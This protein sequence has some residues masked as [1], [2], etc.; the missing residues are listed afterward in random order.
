MKSSQYVSRQGKH[1]IDWQPRGNEMC[2]FVLYFLSS[3]VLTASVLARVDGGEDNDIAT[4]GVLKLSTTCKG[5]NVAHARFGNCGYG[6]F[7]GYSFGSGKTPG[8]S[9]VPLKQDLRTG[10]VDGKGLSYSIKVDY[11]GFP[12]MEL[13]YDRR[14]RLWRIVLVATGNDGQM[15]KMVRKVKNDLV[16][17]YGFRKQDWVGV[18]RGDVQGVCATLPGGLEVMVLEC[19]DTPS[20]MRLE[21]VV[22]NRR[23]LEPSKKD[24]L[25]LGDVNVDTDF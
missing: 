6:H 19:R 13:V 3:F 7:L 25:G 2:R 23:V 17:T 15:A 22:Q 10:G 24:I 4:G 9:P 8:Q 18:G 14:G 20:R 16:L 1:I 12:Q 5:I 11:C 21:V